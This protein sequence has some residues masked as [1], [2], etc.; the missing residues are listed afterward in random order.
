MRSTLSGTNK[1]EEKRQA[2]AL[3]QLAT[4]LKKNGRPFVPITDEYENKIMA[5][6]VFPDQIRTTFDGIPT[7]RPSL[8]TCPHHSHPS[9]WLLVFNRYWW[10]ESHQGIHS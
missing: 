6:V 10:Y 1:N 4:K 9:T 3:A 5:D 2:D 7:F 8:I